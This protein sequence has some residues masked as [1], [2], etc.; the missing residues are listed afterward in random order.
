MP[1]SVRTD[2]IAYALTLEARQH[3]RP[4]ATA[5][6]RRGVELL[7]QALEL[8]PDYVKALLE[9]NYA[10]WGIVR[11]EESDADEMSRLERETY[12]RAVEIAP[13]DPEVVARRAWEAFEIEH[14]WPAAARLL[15][16][17]VSLD[18][19][20]P[21][22]LRWSS[23]YAKFIGLSDTAIALRRREL[24]IDPLCGSCA[25]NLMV[26]NYFARRTD[27]AL[28]WNRVFRE[29]EGEGG[30][31]TLGK[32][33][34][35]RGEAELALQAFEEQEGNSMK[36][37]ALHDLGR[38]Q[39]AR[40]LLADTGAEVDRDEA[41]LRAQAAAWIGDIDGAFEWLRRYLEPDDYR[42]FFLH[43]ND[44]IFE[45]LHD[46]PRWSALRRKVNLS[47]EQVAA[48]DFDPRLP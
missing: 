24:S 13:D 12:H 33:Y 16:R 47:E 41:G 25:Y 3:D 28:E 32:I 2:P 39:E 9:L 14:D 44:P 26:C 46:D 42:Y 15:E 5:D 22:V 37:A 35:L 48:I 4:T 38:V 20:N 10:A 40:V 8:D 27:A 1:R 11:F 23:A 31:I 45:K 19:G 30:Y 34:L 17:A 21:R 7:Q 29:M 36:A 6:P 18:P 43:I